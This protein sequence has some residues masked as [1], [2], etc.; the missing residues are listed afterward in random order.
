VIACYPE[1]GAELEASLARMLKERGVAADPAALS[2][3]AAR[4]GENRLQIR[5]EVEK[6][7]LYVG[8]AKRVTEEDAMACIAEGSTL[9]LD[10]ALLAATAGDAALADRAL[11][12]AFAEGAAAVQVVRAALRHVQRLHLAALSVAKGSSPGDALSSLRPPVFFKSRPAFERAL[13]LWPASAL[14]AAGEALLEAERQT[15][16]TGMPDEAIARAVV[17]ALAR[18]AVLRRRSA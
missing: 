17:M 1:T 18:E 3:M 14:A 10:Q 16:T 4:L 9:D 5:Q 11:D 12:Q 15:K 13:R 2:W 7:A 8:P 6:L